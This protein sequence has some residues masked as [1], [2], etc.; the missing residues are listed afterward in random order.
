[1]KSNNFRV[2]ESEKK[3][4]TRNVSKNADDDVRRSRTVA[5]LTMSS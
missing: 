4:L 5:H 3:A 1:M 2:T